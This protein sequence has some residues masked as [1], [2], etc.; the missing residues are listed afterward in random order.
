MI[1]ILKQIFRTGIV[2]EPLPRD[3]V[4]EIEI[5]GVKLEEA[6]RKRFRRSITIRQV[7]AG[8]CNV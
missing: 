5:V 7:D 6:V 3:A 1:R 8:S 4:Q 2:T